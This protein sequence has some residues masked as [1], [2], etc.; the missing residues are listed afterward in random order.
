MKMISAIK[1]LF[2][3]NYR[4]T[5]VVEGRCRNTYSQNGKMLRKMALKMVY[6]ECWSLYKSGPFFLPEREV[7]RCVYNENRKGGSD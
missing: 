1:R 4:L 3:V 5:V 6:V 7:E 2:A